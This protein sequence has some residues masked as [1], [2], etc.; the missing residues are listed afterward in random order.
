MRDD[1]AK[2]AF[3]DVED[4]GKGLGL[5]IPEVWSEEE[6]AIRAAIAAEDKVLWD[7]DF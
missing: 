1:S 6:V 3:V 5:D 4:A 2:R 7:G